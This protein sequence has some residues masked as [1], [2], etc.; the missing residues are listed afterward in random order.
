MA[1][2]IPVTLLLSTFLCLPMLP[3]TLACHLAAARFQK[4][5]L[6]VCA[7]CV[8]REAC[9]QQIQRNVPAS[10]FS[11]LP[12]SAPDAT[13]T[14]A[15]DGINDVNDDRSTVCGA[16]SLAVVP[17]RSG[18][19][20]WYERNEKESW[21]SS[22]HWEPIGSFSAGKAR[23]PP[24]PFW[25]NTNTNTGAEPGQPS[26]VAT[27]VSDDGGMH[28]EMVHRIRLSTPQQGH[29]Q[30]QQGDVDV[31]VKG[32]TTML[33]FVTDDVFVDEEH[34]VE[35]GCV[36]VYVPHSSSD[37]SQSQNDSVIDTTAHCSVVRVATT[38]IVDME[39]PSFASLQ[40]VVS[41]DI[42]WEHDP[43]AL[44]QSQPTSSSSSSD[45]LRTE[46]HLRTNLHLRYPATRKGGG[47]K[48]IE[49]PPPLLIPSR[50]TVL[51]PTIPINVSVGN[52]DDYALVVAGTI[53]VSIAGALYLLRTISQ[54]FPLSIPT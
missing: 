13:G 34:L 36:I 51:P 53:S 39:Q 24:T 9:C 44:L 33:L 29:R 23:L 11:S 10:S 32:R 15:S 6:W 37:D 54:S 31:N 47:Y 28:R 50:S 26:V 52:D 27:I 3:S 4:G 35:G 46:I 43:T 30:P 12:L 8:V 49:L 17:S 7:S 45:S 42:E 14:V 20:V 5:T 18:M 48:R 2:M 40:H 22:P 1:T 21:L 38:E 25:D 19:F 41:V 16:G